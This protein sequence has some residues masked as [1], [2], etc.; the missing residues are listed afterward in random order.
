[1]LVLEKIKKSWN[2]GDFAK[3]ATILRIPLSFE[4]T[5]SKG[6]EDKFLQDHNE[7]QRL[8]A[9]AGKLQHFFS[10]TE[11]KLPVADEDKRLDVVWKREFNGVPTYAFEIE[12]S[13]NLEK[14]I[15]RLKVAF[16]LWNTKPRLIVPESDFEKVK[17]YLDRENKDFRK[18][19]FFFDPK[20][21]NKIL[22]AK[23]ELR[24]IEEMYKIW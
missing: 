5:G 10:E 6:E 24:N 1:M 23:I 20:G 21:V 19:F 8:L 4:D 7:I 13:H 17:F 3:G 12:I 15:T 16:G 11:Y 18:E 14:A 9:E 22:A 2:I